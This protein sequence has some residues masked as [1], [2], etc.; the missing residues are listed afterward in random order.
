MQQSPPIKVNNM[1]NQVTL[2]SELRSSLIVDHDVDD[3]INYIGYLSQGVGYAFV[4]NKAA[5]E[6]FHI[7]VSQ[8]KRRLKKAVD[9]GELVSILRGKGQGR[10]RQR[11]MFVGRARDHIND[12]IQASPPRKAIGRKKIRFYEAPIL[13]QILAKSL[14]SKEPIIFPKST[15]ISA[16]GEPSNEP[17]NE[18]LYTRGYK[19]TKDTKERVVY[20]PTPTP[21]KLPPSFQKKTSDTRTRGRLTEDE[22]DSLIRS[23]GDAIVSQT[24]KNYLATCERIEQSGNTHG[25][26]YSKKACD[27]VRPWCQERY[28]KELRIKNKLRK[29]EEVRREATVDDIISR[30]RK[31]ALQNSLIS[32][33]CVYDSNE[34]ALVVD[35]RL[36]T[37][38]QLAQLN[39]HG[40]PLDTTAGASTNDDDQFRGRLD[41][42]VGQLG[43][44]EKLGLHGNL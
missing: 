4:S 19:D 38:Y 28:D 42:L 35:K 37:P 7:S 29:S 40:V 25:G 26:W 24:E 1:R 20:P 16:L 36:L 43:T 10:G 13:N 9:S 12:L 6:H 39:Y 44:I 5:A 23:Y 22:R 14:V 31:M 2:S 11:L 18:P 8:L 3:V 27:V 33:Y 34:S 41:K 32:K 21:K 15:P 17:S 30:R